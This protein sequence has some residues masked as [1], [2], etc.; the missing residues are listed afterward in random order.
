LPIQFF[1]VWFSTF[2]SRCLRF[3]A[4]TGN[5]S[6]WTREVLLENILEEERKELLGCL[7]Q[8][9]PQGEL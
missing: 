1:E 8:R 5:Y 6:L 7:R 4:I 2:K 9:H 3:P